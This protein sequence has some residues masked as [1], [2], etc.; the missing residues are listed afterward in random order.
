MSLQQPLSRREK[1]ILEMVS[2]YITDQDKYNAVRDII[3]NKN[4]FEAYARQ[5]FQDLSE[6]VL[7]LQKRIQYLEMKL[8]KNNVKFKEMK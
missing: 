2:Q 5:Q 1:A 8:I 3:Y 7:K 6:T 4:S